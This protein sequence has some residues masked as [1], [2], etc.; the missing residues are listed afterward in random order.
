MNFAI[1]EIGNF[2]FLQHKFPNFNHHNDSWKCPFL[3]ND[4]CKKETASG[5]WGSYKKSRRK[6]FDFLLLDCIKC[7]KLQRNRFCQS[8]CFGWLS[9]FKGF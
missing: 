8:G 1:S 9:V 4:Y 6:P 5:R 3:M 7:K 2:C